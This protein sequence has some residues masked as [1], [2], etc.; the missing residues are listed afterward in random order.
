MKTIMSIVVVLSILACGP[1]H[2]SEAGKEGN[3]KEEK[4]PLVEVETVTSGPIRHVT[5][6][7]ATLEAE[8]RVEVVTET[9]GVVEQILT[10]EG[11]TVQTGETIAILK[12]RDEEIALERA[13]VEY[14][15]QSRELERN[16]KLFEQ[17]LL[18]PESMA[19]TTYLYEQS[20][21]ALDDAKMRLNKT[22]ITAP[23]HGI[24]SRRHI[25]VGQHVQA[26]SPL[27]TL[28]DSDP[29]LAR[30]FLPEET[31]SNIRV[32][33]EVKG[34]AREG[35]VSF[36]SRVLRISPVVDSQT[37][38]VEIVLSISRAPEQLMPGSFVTFD[39]V[40]KVKPAATLVPLRALVSE[41]DQTWVF[42]VN[43]NVSHKRDVKIGWRNGTV[44]EILE[45]VEPGEKVVTV[46]KEGLKEGTKVT[47]EAA[48]PAPPE[49]EEDQDSASGE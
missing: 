31:A 21:V 18:S 27:F 11:R 43:D 39:V 1:R 35:A 5:A 3:K 16:R 38:T 19:Q 34:L 30:I 42:T 17:G 7:T 37:G 4:P 46:G 41:L 49:T 36:L 20:R 28:T 47:L 22:Y 12:H 8:R 40:D 45:G 32:G 25:Y 14:D 10:E 48:A 9:M 15:H 44:A 2:G 33:Q 6:V 23:F 26:L 13:Q 24:V 29:L